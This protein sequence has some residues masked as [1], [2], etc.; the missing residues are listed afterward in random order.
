MIAKLHWFVIHPPAPFI[1]PVTLNGLIYSF[2]WPILLAIM[3]F[4]PINN[5]IKVIGV[6]F[7]GLIFFLD[8]KDLFKEAYKANLETQELRRIFPEL[9]RLQKVTKQ[10]TKNKLIYTT[11]ILL[12]ILITILMPLELFLKLFIGTIIISLF[13]LDCQPIHSVYKKEIEKGKLKRKHPD[14]PVQFIHELPP[15]YSVQVL[16]NLFIA[17]KSNFLRKNEKNGDKNRNH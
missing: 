5:Y 14:L 7:I 16:E 4:M 3:I 1:H 8:I 11:C 17:F 9:E 15:P 13:I 12:L 10:L 6:L 2:F